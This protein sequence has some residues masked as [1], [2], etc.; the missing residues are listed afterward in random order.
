VGATPGAVT[1]RDFRAEDSAATL[2][3]FL[4]A[5]TVTASVDY[6]PEQIAAWSAPH[7]R[8]VTE[9]G[10]S[11]ASTNT[12]VAIVDGS[13][14][15]FSDVD[16]D[17]YIHMMFVAPEFGRRGVARA[18]LGEVESRARTLG[19]TMLSTNASITARPFFERHGFQAVAIQHPTRRG[20][21]LINYRMVR[22]L[23]AE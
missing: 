1:V 16:N 17:G 12:I 14:A 8:S 21:S 10:L 2:S 13:I 6:T 20:V 3:V 19:A 18:L 7:D 4:D 11:R 5:I 9:W 23:P 22:S 15:G